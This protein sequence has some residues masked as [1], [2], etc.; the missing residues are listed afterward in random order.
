MYILHTEVIKTNEVFLDNYVSIYCFAVGVKTY[1]SS[2]MYNWKLACTLLSLMNERA[3]PK[4]NGDQS[5]EQYI[6]SFTPQ[7]AVGLG[8][9]D[10]GPLKAG[11]SP[12]FYTMLLFHQGFHDYT[13]K[14]YFLFNL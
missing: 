2:E 13:F 5:I 7:N 11:S 4:L 3:V 14:N 12:T 6:A 1:Y 8:Y 9:V 10:G